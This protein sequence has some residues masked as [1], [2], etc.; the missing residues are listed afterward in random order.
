MSGNND[1]HLDHWSRLYNGIHP[2]L[3][4]KRGKWPN[5]QAQRPRTRGPVSAPD[6]LERSEDVAR[7]SSGAR[8]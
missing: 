5:D 6:V 1:V 8:G 4:I 2:S 3:F 7:G